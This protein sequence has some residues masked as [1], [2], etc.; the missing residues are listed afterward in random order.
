MD[1]TGHRSSEGGRGRGRGEGGW[2][3]RERRGRGG[4]REGRIGGLA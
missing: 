4:E 3:E 1:Y 2:G